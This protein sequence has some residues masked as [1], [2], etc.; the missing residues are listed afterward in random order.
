YARLRYPP[1]LCIRRARRA[2]R[3]HDRLPGTRYLCTGV[4]IAVNRTTSAIVYRHH[5]PTSANS[6]IAVF[7]H[8]VLVPTGGQRRQHRGAARTPPGSFRISA[9]LAGTESPAPSVPA[10]GQCQYMFVVS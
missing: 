2:G 8:T 1:H 5:L 9:P 3:C 7:G 6:P 4:L 10:T